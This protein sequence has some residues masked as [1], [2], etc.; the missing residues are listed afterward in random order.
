[1]RASPRGWDLCRRVVKNQYGAVSTPVRA[2][3]KVAL[4]PI[5][6]ADDATALAQ[7]AVDAAQA[8]RPCAFAP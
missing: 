5:R 7:L 4:P 2:A 1:M 6:S 3:I 8:V